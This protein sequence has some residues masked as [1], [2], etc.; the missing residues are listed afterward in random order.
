MMCVRPKTAREF[1]SFISAL[2]AFFKVPNDPK[3]SREFNFA[4]R[5]FLYVAGI[6]FYDGRT[7]A[8][9]D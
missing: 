1:N 6:N 9:R 5:H 8:L 7:L 2:R 3:F 4:D